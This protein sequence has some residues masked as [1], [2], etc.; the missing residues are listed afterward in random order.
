MDHIC[1]AYKADGLRCTRQL[2]GANN[3]CGTHQNARNRYGAVAFGT[4]QAKLKVKIELSQLKTQYENDVAIA[5]AN[6]HGREKTTELNRLHGRYNNAK[7]A[8]KTRVD[9]EIAQVIAD[10]PP[11]GGAA[12]GAVG[13]A[14]A[15]HHE[16]RELENFAADKQNVHTTKA[17]EQTKKI[18]NTVL[19]IAVPEGYRWDKH[20]CS[21]TPGEM[22]MECKLS[23]NAAWMMISQYAQP[24]SIYDMGE[25]IYGKVLDSMWQF[26]KTHPEKE[27][28]MAIIR[29]ELQDNVGMCAQGNLTRIC[30]I[31]A[32]YLEGIGSQESLAERLGRLLPPLK[33]I[34]NRDERHIR[35]LDILKENGVPDVEWDS[36]L[37]AVMDE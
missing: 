14:A 25:G 18:V 19:K 2:W 5:V 31:L 35:A 9:L 4:T 37:D 21:K 32:G 12:G 15:H 28:L 34:S 8:I 10:N 26:V 13:G 20:I 22:I 24:T 27:S 7:R 1:F 3:Y 6:L 23:Q 36:W 30:N 29:I 17:V 11:V 33:E 16:D